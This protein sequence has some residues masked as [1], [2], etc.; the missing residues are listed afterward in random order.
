MYAVVGCSNCGGYWLVAD[1]DEQS[2]AQCGR[3]GKRH[4]M[5]RLKRFHTADTRAEAAAARSRLLAGEQEVS[6]DAEQAAFTDVSGGEVVDD[7]EY[8]EAHGIDSEAVSEAGDV[9]S[10]GSRS[11][12]EVLRDAVRAADEREAILDRAAADGLDRETAADLLDRLVRRGEATES[13]GRYRL[14]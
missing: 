12:T 13:G 14:L 3:C 7:D 4:S 2:S 1:P 5:D 6:E 10:G 9:S 8:L 11:R